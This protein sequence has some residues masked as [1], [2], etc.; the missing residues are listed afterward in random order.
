MKVENRTIFPIFLE[1]LIRKRE[2]EVE[3]GK[4]VKSVR[5]YVPPLD[6]W[7]VVIRPLR[8]KKP[9]GGFCSP[10]EKLILIALNPKNN[11]PL[12]VETPVRT[13][14]VNA[15]LYRYTF[16]NVTFNSPNELA[17]FIF[18]HE[19]S[20]LLDYLRGYSLRVKQTRAN[21]FALKHF[22]GDKL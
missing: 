13:E 2:W 1:G 7:R 16:E 21:R 12:T 14:P 10:K 17:R 19:F 8:G 5:V 3:Y 18:L 20:H 4:Y 15:T 9:Y 11:Y 6:N 22:K